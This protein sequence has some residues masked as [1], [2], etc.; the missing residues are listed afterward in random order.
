MT[1]AASHDVSQA[2]DSG[3]YHLPFAARLG[4]V[5]TE[6]E[7]VFGPDNAARFA[8]FP[9]LGEL[10]Q[11]VLWR[12]FRRPEAANFAALASLPLFALSIRGLVPRDGRASTPSRAPFGS[13]VLVLLGIPLVMTH[14]TSTYVDLPASLALSSALLRTTLLPSKRLGKAASISCSLLLLAISTNMRLQHLPPALFVLCVLVARLWRAHSG[15]ATFSRKSLAPFLLVALVFFVPLKNVA[16]H[17]NPVYPVELSLFGRALPFT[18]T[19]YSSS[20]VWLEHASQPVRFVLSLLEVGLP[21]FGEPNRYSIDQWTPPSHPGY[22]MGGSFGVGMVVHLALVS[23]CVCALRG[24]IRQRLVVVLGTFTV[25]TSL[26]PQSHELRYTLY[27]PITL[28]TLTVLLGARAL[29]RL[30]TLAAWTLPLAIAVG[31]RGAWLAPAGSTFPELLQRKVDR[32]LID[33]TKEGGALCVSRP[34]WTWL[35]AAKFHG[36]HYS[37]RED[38]TSCAPS[39]ELRSA[40]ARTASSTLR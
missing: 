11:G 8:G 13:L 20:P 26:M 17:G 10:I 2:W 27:F 34:P 16:L 29:P 30:S 24:P 1:R 35:Y 37:V 6:R 32:T 25:L 33:A 39:T 5:L 28:A 31:T 36:R 3:Y 23:W 12:M 7:Y 18:E 19:R 9:L 40:S 4:G 38:D 15:G 14:A 22:R 21:S